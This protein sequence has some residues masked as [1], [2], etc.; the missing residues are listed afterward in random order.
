[1]KDGL[2]SM[3]FGLFLVKDGL[4]EAIGV[5]FLDSDC[6]LAALAG[7]LLLRFEYLPR[8]L[9][10]GQNN[11]SFQDEEPN[12]F[13]ALKVRLIP[14]QGLYIYPGRCRWARIT[15]PFRTKNP[16]FSTR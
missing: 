12:F 1:M 11:L 8:A 6:S 15:C 2:P 10:L 3:R 16:T 9:P 14:V 4:P 5:F 13:Y 7:R